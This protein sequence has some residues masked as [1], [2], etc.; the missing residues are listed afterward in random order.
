MLPAAAKQDWLDGKHSSLNDPGLYMSHKCDQIA[1][2]QTTREFKL[3]ICSRHQEA[4]LA[5]S[6]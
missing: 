5:D 3:G 1:R 6:L 4:Y 2:K